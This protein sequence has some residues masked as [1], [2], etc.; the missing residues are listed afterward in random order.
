MELTLFFFHLAVMVER[1]MRN[2][3]EFRNTVGR[4]F[5][6]LSDPQVQFSGEDENSLLNG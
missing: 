3:E 2:P 4:H 6:G 5:A 1:S